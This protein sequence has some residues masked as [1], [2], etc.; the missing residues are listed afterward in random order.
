MSWL[1]STTVVNGGTDAP[2]AGTTETITVVTHVESW[3]PASTT[4]GQTFRVQDPNATSE[5]ILVRSTT[6]IGAGQVQWAITRG[7]DGTTPV[8]HTTGWTAQLYDVLLNAGGPIP[9]ALAGQPSGVALLDASGKVEA[10]QL[11]ASSGGTVATIESTDGSLTVTNGSG[12][13]VNLGKGNIPGQVIG[14]TRYAPGTEYTQNLSNDAWTALST[15]LEVTFTAPPSGDVKV[16]LE[17]VVV[18][19]YNPSGSGVFGVA[20]S[21]LN[22]ASQVG[23]VAP[24]NF[25]NA[26]DLTYQFT[27]APIVIYISGLT[28]GTSYTL[29]PQAYTNTP[30]NDATVYVGGNQAGAGAMPAYVTAIAMP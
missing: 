23:D 9:A 1:P 29:K 27:S 16:V 11:P 26:A 19:L 25:V 20:F 21:L 8:A 3:P 10:E 22:G 14:F 7:A 24:V 4:T 30:T 13:T 12:P 2:A 18:A 15:S 6:K 28:A 17:N 5:I